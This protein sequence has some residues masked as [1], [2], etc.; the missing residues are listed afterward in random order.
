MEEGDKFRAQLASALR[1]RVSPTFLSSSL[2]RADGIPSPGLPP[3][4]LALPSLWRHTVYAVGILSGSPYCD[5]AVG[6]ASLRDRHRSLGTDSSSSQRPGV[7]W[8][9]GSCALQ[10]RSLARLGTLHYLVQ[11]IDTPCQ[12]PT[13][14]TV[15]ITSLQWRT[16]QPIFSTTAGIRAKT[17]TG[18]RSGRASARS[19]RTKVGR[20]ITSR[21]ITCLLETA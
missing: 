19:G 4:V 16:L 5:C 21:G 6:R 18:R 15:S 20:G 2:W 1:D 3:P 8:Y 14:Q 17:R 7:L 12:S 11:C 9:A 10:F 13:L